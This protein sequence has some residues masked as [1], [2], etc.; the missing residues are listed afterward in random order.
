MNQPDD[1]RVFQVPEAIVV[2][3]CLAVTDMR[4]GAYSLAAQIRSDLKVN[5]LSGEIFAFFNRNRRHSKLLWFDGDGYALLS[6]RLEEGTFAVRK[7][8]VGYEHLHGV[9]LNR[10]L[11]GVPLERI[12]YQKKLR[13]KLN[14]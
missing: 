7:D 11:M 3:L 1:P 9:D 13:L 5:P 10:L 14:K 2:H 4:K 12:L 8:G 6:K